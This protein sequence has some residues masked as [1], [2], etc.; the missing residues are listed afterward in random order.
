MA[1][2]GNRI[3][4]ILACANCNRQNYTTEKNKITEQVKKHGKLELNKFCK[5]CSKV[6][7]HKEA[8]VKKG[9]PK[10]LKH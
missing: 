7:L 6:V 10:K 2:K 1:K 8:K 4:I 3:K 5:Q 9:S